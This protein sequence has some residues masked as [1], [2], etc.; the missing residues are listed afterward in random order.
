M[1]Y[2]VSPHYNNVLFY[3][4]PVLQS[5]YKLMTIIKWSM[6]INVDQCWSVWSTCWP[7]HCSYS[8][9]LWDRRPSRPLV[10]LWS[11]L[12]WFL[13]SRPPPPSQSHLGTFCQ[14]NTNTTHF[15]PGNFNHPKLDWWPMWWR[16]SNKKY[17]SSLLFINIFVFVLSESQL[18]GECERYWTHN[19]L[20]WANKTKVQMFCFDPQTD[21]SS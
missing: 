16:W 6:L 18:A 17:L 12:N 2:Q 11:V 9:E 14:I 3:I 13:H 19:D 10:S 15:K 20:S 1:I 8:T 21:L 4:W 5:V 7:A